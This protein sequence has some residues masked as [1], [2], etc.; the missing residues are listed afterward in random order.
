VQAATSADFYLVFDSNG[1]CDSNGNFIATAS[2]YNIS[3]PLVHDVSSYTQVPVA[4]AVDDQNG[5]ADIIVPMYMP[6]HLLA[7]PQTA[8]ISVDETATEHRKRKR[9]PSKH[10]R[11]E[12]KR[13]RNSGQAYVSTAGSLNSHKTIGPD[14]S[15][16]LKCFQNTSN[17]QEAIF[18]KFWEMG[19]FGLQSAYLSGKIKCYLPTLYVL[20]LHL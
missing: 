16:H 1:A 10:E 20:S 17:S 14:C 13:P 4:V 8:G 18:H 7:T 15:C 12:Q 2:M 3:D 5:P 19:D 9:K 11:N 6:N